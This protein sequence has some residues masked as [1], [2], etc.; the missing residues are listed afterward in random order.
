MGEAPPLQRTGSLIG[1]SVL[2]VMSAAFRKWL[3]HPPANQRMAL[4][5]LANRQH[6]EGQRPLD[7]WRSLALS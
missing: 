1:G 6:G 2:P 4:L 5:P 3:C 7:G